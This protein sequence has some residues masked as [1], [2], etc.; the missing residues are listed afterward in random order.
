MTKVR[1]R[2]LIAYRPD[3]DVK[4]IIAGMLTL[5]PGASKQDIIDS[6]V[7]DSLD[8]H[9]WKPVKIAVHRINARIEEAV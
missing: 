1:E 7:R 2:N 3:D 4:A 5:N 8:R 9:D 6:L